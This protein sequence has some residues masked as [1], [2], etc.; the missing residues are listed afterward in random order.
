MGKGNMEKKSTNQ[1][2]NMTMNGRN[3]KLILLKLV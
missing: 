2:H 3:V 1:G